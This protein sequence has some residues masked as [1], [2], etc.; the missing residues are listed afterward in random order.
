[1]RITKIIFE[2]SPHFQPHCIELYCQM[3]IGREEIKWKEIFPDTDFESRAE[4][5]FDYIK[6]KMIEIVRKEEKREIDKGE[7]K[8]ER[9]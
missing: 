8:N 2:I 5:Y 4:Q 9:T 6:H 3:T 1:M 7:T